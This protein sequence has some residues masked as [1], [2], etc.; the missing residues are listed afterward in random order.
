M[1][2]KQTLLALTLLFATSVAFAFQCPGDMMKIDE[3]LAQNPEITAEQRADVER[4]RAEGEEL[5][6]AGRHQE[7]VDTLAKALE[8]LGM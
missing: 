1:N 8:I 6:N 2:L 4:Y 7:S 5:H 3:A